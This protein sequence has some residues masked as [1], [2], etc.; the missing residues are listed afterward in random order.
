MK[1][2]SIRMVAGYREVPERRQ[3]LVAE[4][5]LELTTLGPRIRRCLRDSP[6]RRQPDSF[7]LILQ[8]KRLAPGASPLKQKLVAGVRF[9]LT[10]F[11]L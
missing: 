7:S 10:T 4:G 1:S 2:L 3:L 6:K 5:R 9:E 11:G 8:T